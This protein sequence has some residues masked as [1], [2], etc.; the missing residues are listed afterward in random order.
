M[1]QLDLFAPSRVYREAGLVV[2]EYRGADGECFECANAQ[3]RGKSK[4][5]ASP[6]PSA[7]SAPG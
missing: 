4:T 2:S 7:G 6:T 5:D 3:R 1:S